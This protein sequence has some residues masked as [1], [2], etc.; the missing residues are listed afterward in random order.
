MNIELY[1]VAYDERTRAMVEASGFRMLDNTAGERP[2]WYE[3][4]PIR[5]FLSS[6]VLQDDTW[7]GF[8]SPRFG[9]KT[10]LGPRE[11][12][13]VVA[14]LAAAGDPPDLVLFSPQPDMGALFLNVFEQ[15]ELFHPGFL[16][17]AQQVVETLGIHVP[18][19]T[20]VTDARQLVYS[21]Y[22]V[23]RKPF[24]DA[25]FR[26]T[27]A[28]FAMAED[29]AH[30]LGRALTEATHYPGQAQ[31]KV[32]MIERVASLMLATDPRW[33]AV[34]ANT[35]RFAWS[36]FAAFNHDRD[37]AV[38][39][40]ALKMAFREHGWPEYITAFENLRKRIQPVAA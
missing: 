8:V 5:R 2:D 39:S 1:Q 40:D 29:P 30:E 9:E 15:G 14:G 13:S 17:I 35:F 16:R 10:G 26:L 28:I 21:N 36:G 27:E 37:L 12:E 24:W 32:F 38:I 20:L 19:G 23:A 33:R 3:Y 18:L 34:P 7:Y 25:W 31:Q 6:R 4:W 22:F 11:V